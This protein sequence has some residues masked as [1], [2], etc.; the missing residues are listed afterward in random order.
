MM[1]FL[2]FTLIVFAVSMVL[3]IFGISVYRGKTNLIHD[4]HQ[5]KVKDKKKYGRAFGKVLCG[6][7]SLLLI[8]AIIPLIINSDKG[9]NIAVL[10]FFIGLFVLLILLFRVQKQY[11]GGVF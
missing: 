11:N 10:V 4:Y 9:I 5:T 2:L 6:G 7:G 3:I 1:E 8:S